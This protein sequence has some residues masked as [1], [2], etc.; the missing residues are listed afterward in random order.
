M[1]KTQLNSLCEYLEDSLTEAVLDT[2]NEQVLE[3]ASQNQTAKLVK[4]FWD[5]IDELAFDIAQRV[6]KEVNN[7]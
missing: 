7:R 1:N 6:Q 3:I 4:E 5:R 2:V